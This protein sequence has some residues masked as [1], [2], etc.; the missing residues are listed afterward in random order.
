[1]QNTWDNIASDLQKWKPV[2]E[3]IEPICSDYLK[4]LYKPE[5]LSDVAHFETLARHYCIT[6]LSIALPLQISPTIP[7]F[8]DINAIKREL[9]NYLEKDIK[10]QYEKAFN[11]NKALYENE[12]LAWLQAKR[13]EVQNG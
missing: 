5:T 1:M 9:F 12:M 7:D 3:S 10:F 13:E 6:F 8:N 4:V 2:M 11:P